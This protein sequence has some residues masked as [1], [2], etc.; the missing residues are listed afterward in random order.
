MAGAFRGA[1]EAG[2]VR[3]RTVMITKITGDAAE[4]NLK[5]CR[6]SDELKP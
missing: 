4:I 1:R 6:R 5:K 3:C 2:A